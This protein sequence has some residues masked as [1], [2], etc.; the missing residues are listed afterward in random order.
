[1][2]QEKDG[3]FDLAVNGGEQLCVVYRKDGYLPVYRTIKLYFHLE[4]YNTTIFILIA[5]W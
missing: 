2:T 4:V 3:T 1:M 5:D